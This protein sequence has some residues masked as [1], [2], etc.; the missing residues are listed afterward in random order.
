[1]RCVDTELGGRL[2]HR[3]GQRFQRRRRPVGQRRGLA[4]PGQVDGDDVALAAQLVAQWRPGPAV[5]AEAVDEDE[6]RT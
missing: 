5:V 1:M 2:R 6:R 4:V 3:I